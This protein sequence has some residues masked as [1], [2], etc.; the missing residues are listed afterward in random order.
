MTLGLGFLLAVLVGFAAL[1]NYADLPRLHA[2]RNVAAAAVVPGQRPL[3]TDDRIELPTRDEMLKIASRPV[4]E[5]SRRPYQRAKPAAKTVETPTR[6]VAALPTL[7]NYVLVGTVL[8]GARPIALIRQRT[9][10][11]IHEVAPGDIF[12]GWVAQSIAPDKIVFGSP[13]GRQLIEFPNVKN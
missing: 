11:E 9:G 6:P 4:F 13:T 2:E 8:T 5:P 7:E 1:Q 3:D 12:L 10:T